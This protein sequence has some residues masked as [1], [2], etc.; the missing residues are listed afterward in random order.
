[1]RWDSDREPGARVPAGVAVS[2]SARTRGVLLGVG[3]TA[4]L[5]VPA[6]TLIPVARA[7]LMMAI[8]WWILL[9]LVV[10]SFISVIGVAVACLQAPRARRDIIAVVA[11]SAA[12]WLVPAT[13]VVFARLS[14]FGCSVVNLLGLPWPPAVRVL[15]IVVGI[16]II[17][18][19]LAGMVWAGVSPRRRR[20][21]LP[22][23]VYLA[24]MVFPAFLG[25]LIMVYGD[26]APNCVPG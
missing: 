6:I 10:G 18:I 3:I 20:V 12:V 8:A 1:M 9:E 19:A 4:V 5:A 13:A 11:L 21:L 22:W 15:V 2:T 25:L 7:N 17:G 14:M 26:P 23:L 16:A 24:V